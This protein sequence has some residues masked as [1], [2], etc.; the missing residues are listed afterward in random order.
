MDDAGEAGLSRSG[1]AAEEDGRVQGRDP[2]HLVDHPTHLRGLGVKKVP[3][4]PRA[5]DQVRRLGGGNARHLSAS[6]SRE[7]EEIDQVRQ[8]VQVEWTGEIIRRPQAKQRERLVSAV[9]L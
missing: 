9:S 6:T 2:T 5:S 4:Q 1:L 8:A 3:V 7:R